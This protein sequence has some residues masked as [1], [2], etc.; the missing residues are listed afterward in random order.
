MAAMTVQVAAPYDRHLIREVPLASYDEVSTVLDRAR[1]LF[2][3]RRRWLPKYERIRILRN[4]R[5][6][7][8]EGRGSPLLIHSQRSTGRSTAWMLPS[9]N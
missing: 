6:L 8:A 7:L 1:D 2:H 3:D 4:F 9:M 5:D